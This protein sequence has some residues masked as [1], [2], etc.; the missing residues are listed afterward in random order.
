MEER[1]RPP[2]QPVRSS[3][4]GSE[5][6]LLGEADEWIYYTLEDLMVSRLANSVEAFGMARKAYPE[7]YGYASMRGAF[8]K[9]L[10]EHK[11]ALRD[12]LG[13]EAEIEASTALTP[14][15]TSLFDSAWGS[16]P[17]YNERYHYAGLMTLIA[18]NITAETA[19][20][21]TQLAM[22]VLGSTWFP[23]RVRCRA[24]RQGGAYNANLGGNQQHPGPRHT[25]GYAQEVVHQSLL[26]AMEEIASSSP[27]P[28]LAEA[29][30]NV[31]RSAIEK[32]VSNPLDAEYYAE[33]I[34]RSLGRAL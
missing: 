2:F 14:Y 18:K 20:M 24:L 25:R 5:A 10:V 32:A 30:L 22:E 19:V 7:A 3:F 23:P 21:V 34:L 27:N 8:G 26:D 33:G 15:T 16:R 29:S 6:Y 13:V 28:K 1:H 31:V 12:L 9:K 17:P 4:I 11:L